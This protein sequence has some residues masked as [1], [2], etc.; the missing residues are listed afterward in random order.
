VRF[1]NSIALGAEGQIKVIVMEALD[2]ILFQHGPEFRK[3]QSSL[4]PITQTLRQSFLPVIDLKQ[5]RFLAVNVVCCETAISNK[6]GISHSGRAWRVLKLSLM[7]SSGTREAL[8]Q[9]GQS[10][11]RRPDLLVHKRLDC[12]GDQ[13]GEFLVNR[14]LAAGQFKGLNVWKTA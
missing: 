10:P 14:E 12:L 5:C 7:T 11:R 2:P 3:W 8:G 9:L 13:G 6:S 4:C 1:S